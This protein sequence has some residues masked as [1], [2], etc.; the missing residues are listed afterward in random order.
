[1]SS[2]LESGILKSF[3]VSSTENIWFPMQK[4][5][6]LVTDENAPVLTLGKKVID[7]TGGKKLGVLVLNIKETSISDVYRSV[8][9]ASITSYFLLDG[10]GKIVSSPNKDEILK[11]LTN[12]GLKQLI[13]NRGNFSEIIKIDG[14]NMLVTSTSLQYLGWKLVSVIPIKELTADVNKNTFA[15]VILGLL[16]MSL[17]L[18]AATVLS[19][20]IARPL[21]KL[22]K[23]MKEI[24]D[25]NL[26]VVF[27]MT[28][29]DEIGKLASGFNVMVERIKEL[30]LKSKLEEYEL[31]LIQA[32]I[33]PHFLYN[34]LELVY[35]LCGIAGAKDAQTATKSLA[36]FYRVAL[37]EGREVITIEEEIKSV[38]DYLYIQRYKYSDVFDYEINVKD[39]ILTCK[40]LK[41][42]LQPLVE[43]SIYH[44]LKAKGS[45]GRILI[46]G[47]IEEENILIKIIDNGIG[48]S[49]ERIRQIFEYAD[50]NAEKS[51]FGLRNVDERIKLFYG[52]KYGLKMVSQLGQGTEVTVVIPL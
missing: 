21:V 43:N 26:D 23:K 36:D 50:A 1:L 18:F 24:E 29:T 44:G 49:E 4:R 30:L 10:Q 9:P 51:S 31:A 7:P 39:D 32:Q 2:A 47:Y 6:F 37:S 28:S 17:A 16:C 27:N 8:G 45:F 12:T 52:E 48:I 11:P 35:T 42:T 14:T 19:S 15:V 46:E 5:D 20:V 40:I 41:L 3:D 33:K 13:L 38:K 25:G 34:S 22:T